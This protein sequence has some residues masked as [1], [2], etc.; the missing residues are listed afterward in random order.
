MLKFTINSGPDSL[1][2]RCLEVAG[3]TLDPSLFREL[4]V[5]LKELLLFKLSKM[6]LC[7]GVG[8]ENLAHPSLLNLD[9]HSCYIPEK[10]LLLIEGLK[11][12]ESLNLPQPPCVTSKEYSEATLVKVVKGKPNLLLLSMVGLVGVTDRVI[13]VLVG[14]SPKLTVLELQNTSISSNALYCLA[15][16]SCLE[17]LNISRTEVNDS[18]LEHLCYGSSGESLKKLWTDGCVRLSGGYLKLLHQEG[19]GQLPNSRFPNYYSQN[20]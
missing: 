17:N 8:L 18:G 13:S 16:L 11:Q 6:G 14:G 10:S 19:S 7:S 3:I 15:T 9:L 4:P 20:S 1:V 2:D 5:P 12:L